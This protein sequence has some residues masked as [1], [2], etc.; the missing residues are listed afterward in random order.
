MAYE[1]FKFIHILAVVFMAAPLYNLVVVHERRRL[2]KATFLVDRYF[3]NI[4]KGAAIRC[5]V[6]Q[7]TAVITGLLLL[8]LGGFPWSD[9]IG[10]PILLLKLILL[11]SLM[12]LLSIVHFRLQPAIEALLNEVKGDEIPEGIAK[13]IAPIRL[14]RTR[15]ASICLFIVITTVLLGLQ[16]TSRFGPLITAILILIAGLFSWRVY[17]T[18]VRSGWF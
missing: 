1:V 5:Y 15:L 17:R 18:G 8:P 14:R 9:L 2:G 10:N 6:Y 13:Q 11:L 12:G 4:I 16:I 3:E 7:F